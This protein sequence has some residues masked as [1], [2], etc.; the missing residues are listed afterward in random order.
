MKWMFVSAGLK[1]YE[2]LGEKAF[3]KAGKVLTYMIYTEDTEYTHTGNLE[4][5]CSEPAF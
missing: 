3:N 4:M 5:M 2:A 1:S